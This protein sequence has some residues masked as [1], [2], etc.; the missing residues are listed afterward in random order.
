MTK[1]SL[2]VKVSKLLIERIDEFPFKNYRGYCGGEKYEL[3]EN[4]FYQG[5]IFGFCC[6]NLYEENKCLDEIRSDAFSI[7]ES[8]LGSRC[9]LNLKNSLELV[10][11]EREI[12]NEAYKAKEI[13]T[14]ETSF[15][16][17][18]TIMAILA[19]ENNS[20][21]IAYSGSLKHR[22][23]FLEGIRSFCSD[24]S[25]FLGGFEVGAEIKIFF[26]GH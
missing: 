4:K 12:I 16:Y 26:V 21:G 9:V 5:F 22:D 17:E 25:D 13:S 19:D 18:D 11:N 2:I 10:M 3:D 15:M 7:I 8:T 1:G 14:K 6:N 20:P 23:V 24:N